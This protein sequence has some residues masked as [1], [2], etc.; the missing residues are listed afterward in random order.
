MFFSGRLLSVF[1]ACVL[2]VV[3]MAAWSPTRSDLSSEVTVVESHDDQIEV[4]EAT[5][6]FHRALIQA[7][8]KA[9]RDGKM[10]RADLIRLRVAMLS[11]AFRQQAEDLAVIQMSAS[12]SDNVPI[13]DDGRVDRAKIDWEALAAFLEKLIPLILMLIDALSQAEKQLLDWVG[14]TTESWA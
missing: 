14:L 11:P 12:G 13:G 9:V 6:S 1:A 7:A 10:R 3:A 5:T 2:S 4:K 8:T